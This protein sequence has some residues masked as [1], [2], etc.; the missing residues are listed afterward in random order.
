MSE[1]AFDLVIRGGTVVDGSGQPRFVADVGIRD[2]LIAAVDRDLPPG[3]EE[4]D[5]RGK[6]VTPGFVDVHTHYDAQATWDPQLSPSSWHGV[7]TVVMGN[8]GVGFAP[9]KP[10]EHKWL[11]G[12]MEGVEDIPGTAMTEGMVWSW[13][14]FPEYLDSL[15][16]ISRA[17]DICTQVPHGALRAYVMG[18]RGAKHEAANEDDL[19]AM[20][21]IVREGVEAGALGFSSSRT[22]IH[23]GIDGEYVPGTFADARELWA[24]G[25]AV[26]EGGGG[27]FQM[28]GNHVDM[29]AEFGWM[30]QLAAETGVRISFNLLQTDQKPDLYQQML[31]LLDEVSKDDVPVYAQVAGR[32][33]GILMTWQGTAIPFLPYPSYMPLHHLPFAKRLPKLQEPALREKIVAEQPFSF[34]E[35][36]DFVVSSFHKMYRL[37]DPPNYEPEPGESA[38]ALAERQGV[39]PKGI[40]W[41]WL[42]ENEGTG[43][44]YF[45]IFGYARGD[46][47]VLRT[48]LQHPRTRLGLGDGGAHC[49]AI[50][51]ASIQT[52][53]LTHWVRD[54]TRG[55]KLGLEEVVRTISHDTASFYGLDDRGLLRVGYK[56]DVNVIDFDNLRLHPPKIVYDLPASGRRFVQAADGYVATIVSGELVRWQ[57]EPTGK[58]PGKLVRGKQSV[59]Q[60]SINAS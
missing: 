48:L 9:A 55:P 37:G 26:V 25:Q 24:L 44:V 2:G 51:D 39:S 42:L 31:G 41:D 50:C 17:I 32:P 3:R 23:K 40:V 46:F 54:R 10:D 30:R 27:M 35:F 52:F 14:R 43:I 36:E 19:A 21:A 20:A 4:I 7:T 53:M 60:T 15:D 16:R 59:R 11:I 1:H 45:P 34:G 22:P 33:N 18:R 6:L 49:G 12:L 5:A 47:E 29:A 56:A 57:G 8:C 13:E 38:A 58:L 28:T